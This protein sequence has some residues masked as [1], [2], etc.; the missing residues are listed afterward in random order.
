MTT[1]LDGLLR[2]PEYAKVY[3][4]EGLVI[5][6]METICAWMAEN[7]IQRADL[8]RR[9]GTSRANVTQMLGGRNVNLRTLGAVVH[10][11]G[12]VPRF[13]IL[14]RAA[15]ARCRPTGHPHLLVI[16]GNPNWQ[17]RAVGENPYVLPDDIGEPREEDSGRRAA[18]GVAS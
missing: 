12:G 9:L 8:A 10:A 14:P 1:T 6:V 3:A 2:D 18:C 4:E 5:D 13:D 11:L 15:A 17:N 7:D 16:D